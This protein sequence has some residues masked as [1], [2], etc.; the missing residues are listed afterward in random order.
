MSKRE[1]IEAVY[2]E[3]RRQPEPDWQCIGHYCGDGIWL[4]PIIIGF[5]G[6][7]EYQRTKAI[8]ALLDII[9]TCGC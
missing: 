2:E 8:E 7:I 9:R 6:E 1:L 3:V 4:D 5:P